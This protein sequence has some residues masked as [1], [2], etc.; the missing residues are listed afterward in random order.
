MKKKDTFAGYRKL[1]FHSGNIY[2]MDPML[3]RAEAVIFDGDRIAWI[4]NNSDIIGIP[5]DEYELI[6][7]E[8]RTMLPSF[9]DAHVHFGYFALSFLR[10]DI[11]H[12][13]SYEETLREIKKFTRTLRG[14]EWLLGNG[15]NHEKWKVRRLPHKKDL[16]RICPNHPAAVYSR[17][18]HMLWANSRALRAAKIGKDTPD[19]PGGEIVRDESSEPTGVLKENACQLVYERIKAP[20]KRKSFEAIRMAEEAC[21]K[22]GVTAVGNFDGIDNFALLQDYHREH[23]LRVR[24]R[25]YMP[26]RYL[27]HLDAIKIRGGMGDRYLN[28]RGIKI[29]SDGALGSKT[30]LMFKPYRGERH[31]CGIEVSSVDEMA[32]WARRAASLDLSTAIHAIGDKAVRNCLNAFESLP[33]TARRLR[34]RIEHVQISTPRDIRRFA[35]LNVIASVQPSHCSTDIE[36]ARRL[37]GV[38]TKYSYAYRS[39]LKSGAKVALGSD[40]PIENL[41]PFEGVYSAVTR[42]SWDGRKQ[43]HREERIDLHD[44]LKGFTSDCAYALHDESLYGTISLGKSADVIIVND[45]PFKVRSADLLRLEVAAT[46]FEGSCVYGE[47][48]L[49][50]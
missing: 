35:K 45:D 37:W 6:N 39:L 26:V 34:N 17:D 3:P 24:I 14:R 23:G 13:R 4:G 25:Q 12:C 42:R 21:H 49:I 27:D 5:A 46:F 40:A 43:F 18:E 15:W 8:G 19:P 47:Q 2:T 7:L 20:P 32:R 31:N 50:V 9:G 10:L 30:A 41:R 33:R 1:L 28:I 36:L 48:N 44:A 38:R 11:S 29:F 22:Q 16:D